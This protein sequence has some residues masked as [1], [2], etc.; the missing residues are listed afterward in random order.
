[1]KRRFLSFALAGAAACLACTSLTLP[2]GDLANPTEQATAGQT[3]GGTMGLFAGAAAIVVGGDR[4]AERSG[5]ASGLPAIPPAE[6][7]A[8]P[9]T[10]MAGDSPGGAPQ[11]TPEPCDPSAFVTRL[12]LARE[13]SSAPSGCAAPFSL[14]TTGSAQQTLGEF[15]GDTLMVSQVSLQSQTHSCGPPD[16]APCAN[17]FDLAVGSAGGNLLDIVHP[18]SVELERCAL[19]VAEIDWSPFVNGSTGATIFCLAGTEGDRL[20]GVCIFGSRTACTQ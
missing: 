5:G 19:G 18:F 14:Q 8:A 3:A 7:G 13:M 16:T 4:G 6:A 17:T 10:S 12:V 9:Q 20:V 2:L 15:I 11:F 1:M